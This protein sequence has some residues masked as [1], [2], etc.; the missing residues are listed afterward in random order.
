MSVNEDY[1]LNEYSS[2]Q[3]SGIQGWGNSLTDYQVE[4]TIGDIN[5]K[6][7]LEIGAS[8]GE[9]FSKLKNPQLHGRYVALDLAPG[10]TNPVL[11]KHLQDKFGVEFVEG[12]AENMQFDDETFDVSSS[13][14]VLA[15]VN[16]P[17]AVFSELR[18]V[19]KVGGKIV[20]GMPC[21]PGMLNRLIKYIVTY[22]AMRK[23]GIKN[24][25]LIYAREHRNGVGNLIAFAK[26]SFENDT[27]RIKFFPFGLKAWNL[28]LL[29]VIEVIR[30]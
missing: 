28:N 6:I 21:D 4:K 18:R 20:V 16:D 9:H 1:Y 3:R 25:R 13:L 19:T 23:S 2:V 17:E 29:A 24:P 11:M 14:C 7:V 22:P 27:L 10:V 15:H 26:N 12:D 5:G 30:N 8:A